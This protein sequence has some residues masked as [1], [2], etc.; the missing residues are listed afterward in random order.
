MRSWRPVLLLAA[1]VVGI[2]GCG[3]ETVVQQGGAK[4]PP[5]F[6]N[7]ALASWLNDHSKTWEAVLA[8][9]ALPKPHQGSSFAARCSKMD[10]AAADADRLPP[11]PSAQAQTQW[12][13]VLAN[14]SAAVETCAAPKPASVTQF[15]ADALK[16]ADSLGVMTF[17][18]S[19]QPVTSAHPSVQVHFPS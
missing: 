4:S 18:H 8:A 17:G 1:A 5:A 3:T 11:I 10:A 16:A 6:S 15:D 2:S 19:I 7:P 9:A 12:L 13:K 14:L